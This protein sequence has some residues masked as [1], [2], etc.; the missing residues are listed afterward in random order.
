[1]QRKRRPAPVQAN[2]F[3][4]VAEE[5][6]AK[7]RYSPESYAAQ[8]KRLDEA[9]I[10]KIG[11]IPVAEVT[12]TQVL[13]VLRE[14]EARGALEM[15]A[16]CRRMTSQIFRYAVQ[17]ARRRRILPRYLSARSKR[18][19]QSIAPRSRCRNAGTAR[20]RAQGAVRAEH[21]TRV[22]LA[23]AY[24]CAHRGDALRDMGRNR[25]WQAVASSQPLA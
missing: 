1:M 7:Q 18:Q 9:L 3:A 2:T 12:A 16:K 11:A 8:R 17:T 10:P 20:S 13:D 24:R 5:W 19:T 6:L 22:L 15:A 23:V 25:R 4:A 14:F 21:E